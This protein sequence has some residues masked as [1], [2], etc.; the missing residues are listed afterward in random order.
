MKPNQKARGKREEGAEWLK[1]RERER[2]KAAAG[3]KERKKERSK[4]SFRRPSQGR[5]DN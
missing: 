2:R 4:A 1:S 5:F 3:E